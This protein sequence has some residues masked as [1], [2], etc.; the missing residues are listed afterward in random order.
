MKVGAVEGITGKQ[1]GF[2]ILCFGGGEGGYIPGIHFFFFFFF[3]FLGGGGGGAGEDI[4]N[5][6]Y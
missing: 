2:E 1:S 3:F 5:I 4:W 6:E